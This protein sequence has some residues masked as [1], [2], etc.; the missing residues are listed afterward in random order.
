MILVLVLRGPFDL[1]VHPLRHAAL[2]VG[3]T[4]RDGADHKRVLFDHLPN[5]DRGPRAPSCSRRSWAG[6]CESQVQLLRNSIWSRI[7]SAV[8]AAISLS[9]R[10]TRSPIEYRC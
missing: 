5:N 4:G 2:F 3:F 10:R 8:L 7:S 9:K 1:P 6:R